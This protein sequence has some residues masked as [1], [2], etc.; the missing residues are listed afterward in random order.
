MPGPKKNSARGGW[1]YVGRKDAELLIASLFEELDGN[2]PRRGSRAKKR[3]A[4]PASTEAVEPASIYQLKVTLQDSRSAIWRRI[5][6]PADIRLSR[7]HAVLQIVMGWTN[8]HLHGFRADGHRYGIPDSEF[9]G[10]MEILDERQARLNQ[11]APS[12]KSHFSYEYDFGDSWEHAIVV[13]KILPPE[14]DV[15]YTH[16]LAGERACPPEDV[17]GVWG[18]AEFVK[19]IRNSRHPE[20]DEMLE[21]VGGTFDPAAFDLRGVN[22][23]LELFEYAAAP[24]TSRR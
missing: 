18:Y 15:Q 20:H 19:A 21:W 23:M 24:R 4:E 5:Q 1:V 12:V 8:S 9:S 11:I 3:K 7:L 17:G 2:L 16:C 14:P 10:M 13:E 6:L 22:G